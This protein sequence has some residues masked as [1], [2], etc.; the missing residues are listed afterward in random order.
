MNSHTY[1]YLHSCK[2]SRITHFLVQF[3]IFGYHLSKYF[4]H[5][6][7][8]GP[9]E[10]SFRESIMV[11]ICKIV[12]FTKFSQRVK[13]EVLQISSCYIPFDLNFC[14]DQSLRKHQHLKMYLA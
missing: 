3:L 7:P 11:E 6:K 13:I 8:C 5:F 12:I 4:E 1:N 10:F 14:A 2:F 9:P